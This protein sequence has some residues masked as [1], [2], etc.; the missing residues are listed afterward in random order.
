MADELNV[1]KK[2]VG[3]WEKGKTRPK[4]EKIEPLCALYGVTYDDIAWN[5]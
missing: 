3:S 5:V 2:T 1:T 4:L